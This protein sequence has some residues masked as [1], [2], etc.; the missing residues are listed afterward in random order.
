MRGVGTAAVAM[1]LACGAACGVE[2]PPVDPAVLAQA[3]AVKSLPCD[4]SGEAGGFAPDAAAPPVWR[5]A[6]TLVSVRRHAD[7]RVAFVLG[8]PEPG[9][10]LCAVRELVVLPRTGTLLGCALQDGSVRGLGVHTLLPNGRR[11][12]LFWRTDGAG[13]LRS[14]GKDG[15]NY[16]SDTG[17]LICAL[18]DPIQ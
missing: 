15:A 1:L 9:G 10:M 14:G 11:D 17:E 2:S 4:G 3:R 13:G 12:V 8:A 7:A 18:P 5:I 16:E 6:D